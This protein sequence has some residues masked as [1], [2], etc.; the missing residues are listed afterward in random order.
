MHE[1]RKSSVLKARAAR[2]ADLCHNQ[3]KAVFKNTAYLAKACPHNISHPDSSVGLSMHVLLTFQQTVLRLEQCIY[4]SP[5]KARCFNYT[6]THIQYV[7][8]QK[9]ACIHMHI[10]V[11][12]HCTH[13]IN[14][15]ILKQ[16]MV[17]ISSIHEGKTKHT[18]RVG[19]CAC[20][21]RLNH[22]YMYIR[23]NY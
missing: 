12:T 2:L 22:T 3:Q 21:H 6:A 18:V 17:P 7:Q 5:D 13:H 20:H 11:H 15:T 4:K 10:H 23:H 1:I 14:V 9:Y 16:Q 8:E 19:V